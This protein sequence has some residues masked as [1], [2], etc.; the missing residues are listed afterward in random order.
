MSKGPA[1]T[2]ID[3]LRGLA[4]LSVFAY[5]GQKAAGETF[6][7]ASGY[8]AVDLF[9]LLS[10]MVIAHS[11]DGRIRTGEMSAGR[12][13]IV[14]IIR[15]YPLYAL[16]AMLGVLVAVYTMAS[17]RVTAFTSAADVGIAF[18]LT[19]LFVPHK[20][21]VSSSL[22]LLNQPYW[23]LMF[24]LVANVAF[25]LLWR[26]LSFGALCAMVATS[27]VALIALSTPDLALAAGNTWAS[28]PIGLARVGFSFFLGVLIVRH[29]S[30]KASESD[31]AAIAVMIL[32]AVV[33]AYDPI[34][35]RRSYDLLCAFAVFPALG[36][37]AM[38]YQAGQRSRGT[39][40]VLGDASYGVYV[41]HAPAMA[42]AFGLLA[43]VVPVDRW[44]PWSLLAV[45]LA[46]VIAVLWLDRYVD[47]P[48]RQWLLARPSTHSSQAA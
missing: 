21:G 38:R 8:L 22:F 1:L 18:G 33:L 5:H 41:L 19:L 23:S 32:L 37:V 6:W 25:V 39:A 14:R 48:I 4:A 2:L 29:M 42:I 20:I 12:F 28:I 47:R 16:G 44:A 24:E 45:A 17:G 40:K 7:P 30:R 31:A 43:F 27:G 3:A 15:F 9:F 13:M 34:G 26:W 36:M 11:Y 46:L 35:W 10:G